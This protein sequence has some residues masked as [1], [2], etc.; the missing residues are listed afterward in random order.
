MFG[1][2]KP[3]A[4]KIFDMKRLTENDVSEEPQF[5]EYVYHNFI[6]WKRIAM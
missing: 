4:T 1:K 3:E 2:W 6:T 5:F